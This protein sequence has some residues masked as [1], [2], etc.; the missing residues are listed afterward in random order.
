MPTTPIFLPPIES[1]VM[2]A[3]N[4]VLMLH[5][6]GTR[7]IT[8]AE[9]VPLQARLANLVDCLFPLVGDTAD[10]SLPEW[11]AGIDYTHPVKVAELAALVGA[12]QGWPRSHLIGLATSAALMNVGYLVLKR[13]LLDQ[14][15]AFTPDEHTAHVRPHPEVAVRL[16]ERSGLDDTVVSTIAAHHERWDG[17]GYPA[18]LA[19]E[20]IP[21]LARLLAVCDAYVAMRS[22]RPHRPPASAEDTL[23]ALRDGAGRQ[24]SPDAV[25]ALSAA[26]HLYHE[27]HIAPAVPAADPLPARPRRELP[28]HH[29]AAAASAPAHP[30]APLTRIVPAQPAPMHEPAAC[31]AEPQISRAPDVEPQP[32]PTRIRRRPRSSMFGSRRYIDHRSGE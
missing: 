10:L 16:L 17:R 7:P 23:E 2:E 15:R 28:Q 25:A 22:F 4:A 1:R 21:H 20:A 13:P 29:E 5:H 30:G 26:L 12:K 19:G 27:G 32:P 14:P 6:E 11:Q 24:F 31:A 9:L 8:A 18:G 3:L